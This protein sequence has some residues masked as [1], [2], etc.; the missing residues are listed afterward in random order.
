MDD[1]LFLMKSCLEP[2]QDLDQ[3]QRKATVDKSTAYWSCVS[4][5]GPVLTQ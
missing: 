5:L 3:W 1:G 2:V 4:I